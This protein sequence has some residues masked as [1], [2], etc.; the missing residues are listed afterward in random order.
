MSSRSLAQSILALSLAGTLA[1][2]AT[3]FEGAPGGVGNV[4][5]FAAPGQAPAHPAQL[6]GIQLLSV[7]AC[8][9]SEMLKFLP[10]QP[11]LLSDIP[12]ASRIALPQG[13]G[14]LYRYSRTV[15]AG[16]EFG[17]FVVRP[18]AQA[19]FLAAFPGTGL[20]G[21]TDPIQ[22]AVGVSADGQC[23]LVGTTVAA[24]GDLFEIDVPT[25]VVHSIT[26]GFA[27]QEFLSQGLLLLDTWG[28][29]LTARGPLR[30]ARGGGAP[31][32]VP[33]APVRAGAA[34]LGQNRLGSPLSSVPAY[35]GPGLVA[36]ADGSTVAVVAGES[37]TQAHVFAFHSSGPAVCVTD[38]PA[39]VVD[40][41][42]L[43][44]SPAG[45]NL[46]LAPDGSRAAWKVTGV[47]GEIF[48]R[49]VP[50][51]VV[52][53]PVQIT[54]DLNFTDTLNDTGV[55]AF[56]DPNS[57]FLLVG[58]RNGAGGIENADIYRA[59][60]TNG[61]MALSNMSNTSGDTTV[62]FT[63][64]GNLETTDGVHVFPDRSGSLYF[65][66]GSSGQGTLSR[67]DYGTGLVDVVRTGVSAMTFIERGVGG[68][69]VGIVHDS[70]VQRELLFV[71]S[72]KT[73]P[74][75]TMGMFALSETFGD[76]DVSSLGLFA[77]TI[78]VVGGRMLGTYQLPAGPDNLF[79][80]TPRSFGPVLGFDPVGSVLASV[81]SGQTTA[82]F[83]WSGSA[84]SIFPTSGASGF[85]L[86]R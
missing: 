28:V 5:V 74:V 14:S 11:L 3:V 66:P 55:I 54:G 26:Q 76:V 80:A 82:F 35:I 10:S 39:A 16:K 64:K 8:G 12:L 13:Q 15:P 52:P 84:T 77:G 22:G 1:A 2:Q 63:S 34:V 51:S 73:Q 38:T 40:P 17:F 61:N 6:Q 48:S 27:P 25:G 46:A 19:T 30:F 53:A 68:L 36:S 37:A 44:Q 41:G 21:T 29:A 60:F 81:T 72:D 58:E 67:L 7:D 57:V 33:L 83:A 49:R 18:D 69:V 47:S 4:L 75:Q 43:P 78:N 45:P 59:T 56:F 65:I 62:P 50:G 79:S 86:P 42:F 71:P 23:V 24:G 31:E 70:P 9:R 85:I 20:Q 32:R